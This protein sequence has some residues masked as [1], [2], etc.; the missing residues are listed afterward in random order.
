MP[1]RLVVLQ[2]KFSIC[3]VTPTA[4]PSVAPELWLTEGCFLVPSLPAAS[5]RFLRWS[6]Q[7]WLVALQCSLIV[8][9]SA[10]VAIVSETTSI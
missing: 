5:R 6:P 1:T 7:V 9:G 10:V 4:V 2:C 8:F 3:G